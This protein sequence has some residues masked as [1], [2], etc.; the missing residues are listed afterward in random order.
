VIEL[1][2]DLKKNVSESML[3]LPDASPSSKV[4][5]GGFISE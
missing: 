5:P 2:E 3:L 4:G 1:L